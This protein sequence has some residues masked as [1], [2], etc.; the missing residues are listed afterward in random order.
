[1][2][3]IVSQNAKAPLRIPF[4]I[5]F[6]E[7]KPRTVKTKSARLVS[8]IGRVLVAFAT[9]APAV[10]TTFTLAALRSI[11]PQS[12]GRPVPQTMGAGP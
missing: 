4:L 8:V 9:E 1:M 3:F 11:S 7:L 12:S 6:Q 2:L 10:H 5:E